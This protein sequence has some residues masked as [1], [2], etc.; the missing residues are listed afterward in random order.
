M[1]GIFAYYNYN[2]ARDRRAILD[3][4]FTGL[5]RLEY[6]GY[7]SAGVSVD[8]DSPR[9]D[10][11]GVF[12]AAVPLVIKEAGK[13]D[14]LVKLAESELLKNNVVMDK[15]LDNHAGIAHTRWAT[16]GAPTA[17]NAH[18]H[19]SDSKHE[20]VV[21][22]NG[23]ITNY[24]TLKDFLVGRLLPFCMIVLFTAMKRMLF[25]KNIEFYNWKV[26]SVL[27]WQ[28]IILIIHRLQS[29]LRRH[30][31]LSLSTCNIPRGYQLHRLADISSTL[32]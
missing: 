26:C 31:S 28:I 8:A 10:A 4:L 19:V 24:S 13:I 9:A 20:F 29:L 30:Q 1:C 14:N 16:H 2:V 5:R 22:H 7:D 12:Q 3:F 15:M 11:Q 6:R 21:V 27:F 17:T 32:N 25:L 18:P 23:I